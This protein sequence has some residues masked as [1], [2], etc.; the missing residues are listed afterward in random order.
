[1]I[2]VTKTVREITYNGTIIPLL[3]SG[4]NPIKVSTDAEMES[5]LRDDKY[6]G[7]YIKFIGDSSSKYLKDQVYCVAKEGVDSKFYLLESLTNPASSAEVLEGFECYD[8][9]GKKLVGKRESENNKIRPLIE[10]NITSLN[11]DNYKDVEVIGPSAFRNCYNLQNVNFSSSIREIGDEAFQNCTTL[12]D[13]HIPNTVK[14]MGNNVFDGCTSLLNVMLSNA[15]DTIG[16]FTFNGCTSLAQIA[17][18]EGIK[19]LGSKSFMG[20]SALKKI[21]IPNTVTEIGTYCFQAC[22]K[23][24]AVE[25]PSGLENL[26]E[27]AFR[28]CSLLQECKINDSLMAISDYDF[29]N[30]KAMTAIVI[31][32]SITKIGTYAFYGTGLKT[33]FYKGTQTQWSNISKGSNNTPLTNAT[34]VYEFDGQERT[35]TF[36]TNCDEILEPVTGYYVTQPKKLSKDLHIFEGWYTTEDF[37]GNPVSFPYSSKTNLVLYAKWREASET[38]IWDSHGDTFDDAYDA[39]V[40]QTY[41]VN[42]ATSGA[43]KYFKF[44]PTSTR[45]YTFKSTV[46]TTQIDTYGYLYNSSHNQLV[47]N[48]DSGGNRQFYFTYNCTAGATYYLRAACY[49]SGT[50]IYNVIIT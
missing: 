18:P 12:R 30:C 19:K 3:G 49:G 10:R 16:N 25:L 43:G 17:I 1:M 27:G 40:G 41:R 11:F 31:P 8:D 15:T 22:N 46:A 35:Y 34:V 21:I 50:G 9:E 38:E 47:S 23:L 2:D 42:I 36:V 7:V 26:L 4:D 13:I 33:V 28:D 44:V 6:L 37:S 48:D 14:T 45:S 39:V 5:Y 24:T 32:A 29:Y 20:C